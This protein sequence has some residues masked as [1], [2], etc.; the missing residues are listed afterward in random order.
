MLNE[1]LDSNIPYSIHRSGGIIYAYFR[2][3]DK[4]YLFPFI[5]HN[6]NLVNY[7]ISNHAN[8]D[9]IANTSG[10]EISFGL[11]KTPI[12]DIE[13][14]DVKQLIMSGNLT[15][16]TTGTGDAFLVFGTVVKIAIEFITKFNPNILIMG[17][18]PERQAIYSTFISR[19]EKK[20]PQYKVI[21]SAEI[22]IIY[23]DG[24]ITL[25]S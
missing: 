12:R 21:K 19:L 10:F 24:A 1:T 17:A 15:D 22:F 5:S 7:V 20:F 11:V 23:K 14:I 2:I 13:N 6:S 3:K 16:I 8:I 9:A 18:K 4:D 25:N